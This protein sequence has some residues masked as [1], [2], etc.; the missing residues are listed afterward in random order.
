MLQDRFGRVHDYLRISFTD[1]CNLKC[2]YCKPDL[3]LDQTDRPADKN[4]QVHHAL[5]TSSA[6]E[7]LTS[8]ELL[9]IAEDFVYKMGIKKI[10]ITGGEPLIRKDAYALIEQLGSLPVSLAITT[11]GVFLDRF[12]PLFKKIGLNTINIS[13]DS[14]IPARFNE[15]TKT[16]TFEKVFTNIEL[17]VEQGFHVKINA[18]AMKNINEDE[19]IDFVEWTRDLPIHVRFIEFMPFAGNKWEYDKVVSYKEILNKIT[20]V[21]PIEKLNDEPNSTTKS[22]RVKSFL[23]TFAVISSITA[24]FCES[25][26]RIRLTTDGKIKNCLFSNDEIDLKTAKRKGED[27]VPIVQRAISAKHAE[28]GGIAAFNTS[29]VE[30]KYEQGRAMISI[31][32]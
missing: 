27:I 9:S 16:S 23:G 31:G 18:V 25:C 11:N 14:L 26:N 29:G 1:K 19:I 7:R 22:Y 10:R 17:A 28:R 5:C 30:K 12:L 32:G 15:I 8:S 6:S 13:L 3:P 24:P 20:S 21:F 2:F 4:T